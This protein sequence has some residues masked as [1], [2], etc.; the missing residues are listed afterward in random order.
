V[1][2]DRFDPADDR[3]TDPAV[4]PDLFARLGA[5][6]A[7]ELQRQFCADLLAL[8]QSLAAALGPVPDLD[9]IA[10]QAHVLIA[11]A[12]SAGALALAEQARRLMRVAHRGDNGVASCMATE[13]LSRVD[14]LI[15]FVAACPMPADGTP[16]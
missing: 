11:L 15:D 1:K 9:V 5:A 4:L 3:V 7:A 13:M 8:R 10:R 2:E 14:A 12:G 6:T 16:R